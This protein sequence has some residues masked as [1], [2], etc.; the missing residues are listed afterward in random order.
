MN[1]KLPIAL[2]IVIIALLV[3]IGILLGTRILQSSAE[4]ANT[5]GSQSILDL[6]KDY[7]TCRLLDI[8]TI[9]STLGSVASDLQA[10]QNQGIVSTIQIGEGVEDIVSDAQICVYAFTSGGTVENG[11]NSRNAFIVQKTLF[12][13]PGGPMSLIEQTK[14]DP[15]T[16]SVDTLGDSAFYTSITDASGPGAT[17]NFELQVYN[18]NE[19]VS[20]QIRQ[21]A[22]EATFTPETAKTALV[23]LAK[24]AQ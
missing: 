7:G 24:S 19:R 13:N 16:V 11:F 9:Q 20:Y 18:K 21:P 17:N 12:T 14:Q 1:K 15:T 4:P 8:S 22:E 23:A 2:I 5:S 3:T 6:S 10:P